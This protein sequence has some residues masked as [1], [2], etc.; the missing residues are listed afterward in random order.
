MILQFDN[1][2]SVCLLTLN[3]LFIL[4]LSLKAVIFHVQGMYSANPEVGQSL[5]HEHVHNHHHGVDMEH[6]SLAL[7]MT[8]LSIAVKEGYQIY[9]YW[10]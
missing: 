10:R 5:T 9:K 4:Y 3:Q 6:P 1:L 7:S 2:V 8:V